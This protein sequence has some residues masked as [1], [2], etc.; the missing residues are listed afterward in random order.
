MSNHPIEKVLVVADEHESAL[1]S[2][3]ELLQPEQALKVQMVGRFIHQKEIWFLHQKTRQRHAH[4]P[5]TRELLYRPLK[6]RTPEAHATQD[7]FGTRLQ[8]IAAR[9]LQF[10]LYDTHP[11]YEITDVP[12]STSITN[13][14]LLTQPVQLLFRPQ[15][16]RIRF[17]YLIPNTHP[18]DLLYL[19]G[20]ETHPQSLPSRHAAGLCPLLSVIDGEFVDVEGNVL[21]TDLGVHLLCMTV[22]IRPGGFR[23]LPG[24]LNASAHGP[25]HALSRL[26]TQGAAY[27]DTPQ[28]N[29]MSSC[30]LPPIP[31]ITEA[32]QAEFRIGESTLMDYHTSFHPPCRHCR[33]DLVKGHGDGL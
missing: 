31:Q 33:H 3:E 28:G 16:L 10:I 32:D 11:P 24:L 7:R 25:V 13:R 6:I 23:I 17:K 1:L 15:D 26:Y 8:L 27:G 18:G 9:D 22:H 20:Q 14:C 12:V 19:L 5:T 21:A 4:A 2:Q 30:G 29:G